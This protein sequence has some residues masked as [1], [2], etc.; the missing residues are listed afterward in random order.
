MS[1]VASL[2]SLLPLR[3]V[4]P[5]L[6]QSTGADGRPVWFVFAGMGTQWHGMGR[7]LMQVDA[8]KQSILRSDAVLSRHGLK[9]FDMLMNGD[10]HTYENTLNSFVGIAAIQVV[11]RERNVFF[12]LYPVLNLPCSPPRKGFTLS[13]PF[14]PPI[15]QMSMGEYPRIRYMPTSPTF[16]VQKSC[17]FFSG[18]DRA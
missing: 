17:M 3:D 9:L 13:L 6:L 14:T 16:S 1:P 2:S 11:C 5:C 7:E 8:F 10:E 12:Y 4:Q 18:N 15:L